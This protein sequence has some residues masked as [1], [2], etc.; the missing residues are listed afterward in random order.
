MKIQVEVLFTQDENGHLQR[1]N[2]PTG[3]AEPAPYANPLGRT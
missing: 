3:T 1:I 2:E